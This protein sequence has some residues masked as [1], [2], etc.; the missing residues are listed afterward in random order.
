MAPQSRLNGR[1]GVPQPWGWEMLWTLTPRYAS[2]VLFIRRGHEIA[3]QYHRHKEESFLV[4]SGRLIFLVED[5]AGDL[6]EVWLEAG[7]SLHVP[8]GRR[9]RVV[10]LEDSE[11]L[12]V[13]TPEIDDVERIE[14]VRQ[15][16][17]P[18]S[19]LHSS[20]Y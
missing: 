3:M 5:R 1:P 6:R 15:R 12:E 7:D 8:P 14:D 19:D 13:S 17:R 10:A 9:H 16:R 18:G 11:V 2:K 20:A 4:R